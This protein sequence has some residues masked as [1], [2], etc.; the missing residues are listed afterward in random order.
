MLITPSIEFGDKERIPIVL[1][2]HNPDNVGLYQ[3]FGFE[4]VKTLTSPETEIKQ[5]CMIRRHIN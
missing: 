3:H 4:L 2:T 1:E 5:Y